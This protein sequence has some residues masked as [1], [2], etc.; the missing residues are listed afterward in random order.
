MRLIAPPY[1]EANIESA[2]AAAEGYTSV[3]LLINPAFA[4]MNK[5]DVRKKG[6]IK[7][8]MLIISVIETYRTRLEDS[9]R[10]D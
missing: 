3:N 6:S 9:Q 1:K 8:R 7:E 10:M 2:I 5:N 4:L